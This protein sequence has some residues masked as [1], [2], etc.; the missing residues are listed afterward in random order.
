MNAFKKHLNRKLRLENLSIEKEALATVCKSSC[1]SR[2][3]HFYRN[4]PTCVTYANL[5]MAGATN[6]SLY[7]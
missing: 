7:K 4:L 1:E 6:Y 2:N 3:S 5:R